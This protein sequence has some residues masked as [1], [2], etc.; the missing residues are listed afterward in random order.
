MIQRVVERVMAFD[1]E[2]LRN[3][4]YGERSAE[5]ANRRNGYR[6]RLWETRAG[7]VNVRIPKL[8]LGQLLSGVPKAP[9]ERPEVPRRDDPGSLYAGRLQPLGR[10]AGEGHG[11]ERDLQESGQPA[12]Q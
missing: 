12:V 7:A 8:P 10:R 11:H 6:E 9:Q 4:G 2:N 1:V 3:A 5:R